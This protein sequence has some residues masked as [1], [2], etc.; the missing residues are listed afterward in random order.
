MPGWSEPVS[1]SVTGS[2]SSVEPA[3]S[4][5]WSTTA[6]WQA[7]GVSVTIYETSAA[8]QVHWILENS[9]AGVVIVENDDLADVV[10]EVRDQVPGL[11][12]VF[13]IEA[14]GLDE[15]EELGRDVSPETLDERAASLEHDRPATLVYTSGT[16]R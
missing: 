8:D 12:R 2:R 13:V 14:G 6:V 4:G 7:G 3:T 1:V 15:L 11:D 9:G 5:R 10:A 16:H